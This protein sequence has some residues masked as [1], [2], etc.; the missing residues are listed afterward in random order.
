M[1]RVLPLLLLCWCL[2]AL[3]EKGAPSGLVQARSAM[4]EGEFERAL[5]KIELALR[6]PTGPGEAAQLLL[7][8]GQALF[9][10][11]KAEPAR[12]AFLAALQ[13]DPTLELDP[14]RTNPDALRLFEGARASI[15]STLAVTVTGGEA[16][17]HVD[18]RDLGPAPLQTQLAGG[19]HVIVA[20][21]RDGRRAHK[22][23]TTRPG[24]RLEVAL[25]LPPVEAS[26]PPLVA[27]EVAPEPAGLP[28]V[29]RQSP[30]VARSAGLGALIGGA[31]LAGAGG[32]MLWQAHV[33]YERLVS[34][35][36]PA[37]TAEEE[38]SAARSGALLQSLGWV[39]VGVGV[40]AA[41]VGA[42]L[43]ALPPGGAGGVRV[44]A[45]GAPD[46]SAWLSVSGTWP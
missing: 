18:D 4:A 42:G 27:S 32:V 35:T 21:A 15:P 11:G 22:E 39:G 16:T 33:H 41:A 38:A 28:V 34:T 24:L 9:A 3:A 40:A 29:Q 8:R 10:L 26:P 36:L 25:E 37:L 43:L 6:R 2:P 5:K 46:G 7:L 20:L 30:G 17:L 1:K 13:Q 12:A 19:P 14:S 31:V 23:V 45:A 44:S